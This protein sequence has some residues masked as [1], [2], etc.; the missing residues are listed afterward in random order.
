MIS[1]ENDFVIISSKTPIY[2]LLAAFFAALFN[3]V[4]G[5]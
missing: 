2:K 3:W 4:L 1:Y 5:I